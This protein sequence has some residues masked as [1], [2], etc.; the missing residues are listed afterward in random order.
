MA[1]CLIARAADNLINFQAVVKKKLSTFELLKYCR[2]FQ[3]QSQTDSV[4]NQRA[5][6][7]LQRIVSAAELTVLFR[8]KKGSQFFVRHVSDI[9]YSQSSISTVVVKRSNIQ[10]DITSISD[11]RRE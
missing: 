4:S 1:M 3:Q 9:W 6:Q 5:V 10:S 8:E 7:V 11:T 2:I